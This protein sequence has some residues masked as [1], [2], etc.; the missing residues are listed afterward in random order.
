MLPPDTGPD[1]SIVIAAYNAADTIG[2]AIRSAAAQQ[3]VTV[4]I[5]VVD[6]CSTDET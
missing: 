1:V 2:E 3:G 6:D 4:E 5:L